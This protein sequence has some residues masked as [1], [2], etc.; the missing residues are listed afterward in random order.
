VHIDLAHAQNSAGLTVTEQIPARW[1]VAVTTPTA[2]VVGQTLRWNLG[3]FTRDRRLSYEVIPGPDRWPETFQGDVVDQ[4]AIAVPITGDAIIIP[5]PADRLYFQQGVLPDAGYVG[6]KDAYIIMYGGSVPDG[7]RNQGEYELIEEGDWAGGFDDNKLILLRFDLLGYVHPTAIVED[8]ALRLYYVRQRRTSGRYDENW[9]DHYSYA[10]MINRDWG[11]GTGDAVD[12]PQ[13]AFGECSWN[14]AFTGIR[15]WRVPGCRGSDDILSP[16][17]FEVRS[18]EMYGS[19][20]GVW[21]EYEL[22]DFVQHWVTNYTRN[23]GMKISQDDMGTSTSGYVRGAY[24][25]ASSEY[26]IDPTQRPILTVRFQID[27]ATLA[28]NWSLYR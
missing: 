26:D 17:Q 18:T 3:A 2:S 5:Q 9:V 7:E 16:Q 4:Y 22:T 1:T 23:F 6:C 15:P 10:H 13:A 20:G 21:V 14:S 24:D 25:F 8:A 27:P 19:V 11:E 28:R 12:G